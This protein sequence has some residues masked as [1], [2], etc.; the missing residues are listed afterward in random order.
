MRRRSHGGDPAVGSAGRRAAALALAA[1]TR[2][3]EHLRDAWNAEMAAA[4]RHFRLEEQEVYLTVPRPSM[5]R[6]AS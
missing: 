2:I 5:R 4:D 1:Q 3:L 6:R